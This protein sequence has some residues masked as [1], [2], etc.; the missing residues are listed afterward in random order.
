MVEGHA[1]KERKI[2]LFVAIFVKRDGFRIDCLDLINVY[3]I[4][5]YGLAGVVT[6]MFRP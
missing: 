4:L 5:A 1:Q 3:D 6:R 2:V